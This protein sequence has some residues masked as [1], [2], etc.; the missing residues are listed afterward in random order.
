[1]SHQNMALLNPCCFWRRHPQTFTLLGQLST[2]LSGPRYM[3]ESKI[4]SCLDSR[5]DIW[6]V[7]AGREANEY[8]VGLCNS[9]QFTR[10][11]LFKTVVVSNRADGRV[12]GPK[13]QER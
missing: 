2:G 3:P 1:M 7:S 5:Q 9:P 13:S 6:A 4:L 10:K 11:D 12:V 8:I